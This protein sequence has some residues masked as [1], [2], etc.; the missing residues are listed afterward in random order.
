MTSIAFIGLGVMGLPMAVNLKRRGH[1]VTGVVRPGRAHAGAL[2][3]GLAVTDDLPRA[4]SGAD[5][6]ITMLPDTPDVRSALT[7]AVPHL[8]AGALVIDMSTIDPTATREIRARIVP[9]SVGMLDAPVS[10]GEAGAVDG[11][12]SI[13]VGGSKEHFS[14]AL[15]VFEAMGRTIVHV[16]PI[17]AGQVVKAANQLIVAGNIQMVAEAVAFLDAQGADLPAALDVIGGGLAGST[18]LE[19]KRPAFLGRSYRPGFRLALHAK[20]LGIVQDT[21]AAAGLSLPLTAAVTQLVRALVA[22][23]DGH[24]DHAAL[25]KLTEELNGRG[26]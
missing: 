7:D 4:V 1:E 22:R 24:L 5:V 15:P 20:D 2:E 13:M 26:V 19:R 8:R 21:A 16:G 3:A 12:L 9:E 6:V 11:V 10:G 23:G 25:L 18:V 14:A 17:G